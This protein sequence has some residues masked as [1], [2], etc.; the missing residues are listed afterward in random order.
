MHRNLQSG[1]VGL[2]AEIVDLFL[3]IGQEAFIFRIV[4]IAFRQSGV[5]RAKASVQSQAEAPADMGHFSFD[6]LIHIHGLEKDCKFLWKSPA[7][8]I[9]GININVVFI[10]DAFY[11]VNV[12][13]PLLGERIG[14]IFHTFK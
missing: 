8:D 6:N 11:G 5:F 13:N 1:P 9:Y 3:G 12:A 7:D 2:D 10:A 4:G 14:G